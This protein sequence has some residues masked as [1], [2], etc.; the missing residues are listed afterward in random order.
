MPMHARGR[1]QLIERDL[2]LLEPLAVGLPRREPLLDLL[3][4]DD[5]L[6]LEIDQ[7]HLAGLQAA[8]E[9]DVFRLHG[10]TPVSDAMISRS[11]CVTR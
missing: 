11:S 6:L 10:S 2:V 5:A 4:G 1:G 7:E 9:L 3:V 8:L